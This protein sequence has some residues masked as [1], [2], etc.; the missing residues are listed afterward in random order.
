MVKWRDLSYYLATWEYLG[1][2]CGLRNAPQAIKDYEN[3]RKLM[4]PKKEK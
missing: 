2:D 1:E 3:L 4:D